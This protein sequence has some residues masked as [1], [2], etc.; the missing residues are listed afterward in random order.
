MYK[1]Q[2]NSLLNHRKFIEDALQKDLAVLK[3]ILA[4]ERKKL[5]DYKETENRLKVELQHKRK[6]SITSSENLLYINYFYRLSKDLNIQKEKVLKA[7]RAFGQKRN[8][9]IEAMKNRKMLDKLKEKRL[10][11]YIRELEKTELD[12]LNEV[13]INRFNRR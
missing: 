9:L 6:V 4:K 2:L 13:A 5:L 7:E 3:K 8:E 1:F 10:K 11:S 12:F